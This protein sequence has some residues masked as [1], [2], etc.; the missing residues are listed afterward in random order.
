MKNRLG[1]VLEEH[2]ITNARLAKG[3]KVSPVTVSVW[4]TNVKQ[5]SW[6]MLYKIAD[7]IP[8]DVRELLEPNENSPHK[9]FKF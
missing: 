5:P 2:D 9:K 6:N 1:I 3:I 8:C 7:F 4:R